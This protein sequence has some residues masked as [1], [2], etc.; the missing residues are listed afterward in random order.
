M[1]ADRHDRSPEIENGDGRLTLDR[2]RLLGWLLGVFATGSIAQACDRSDPTVASSRNS[3]REAA[4]PS[5]STST[6]STSI[7]P[8][9]SAI[10]VGRL[11]PAADSTATSTSTST[12]VPD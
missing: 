8:A 3:E 6:T 4:R 5:T 1:M 10:P 7:N 9:P 12:T 2:R 11:E